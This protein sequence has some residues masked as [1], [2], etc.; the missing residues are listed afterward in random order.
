MTPVRLHH[1]YASTH[2]VMGVWVAEDQSL[3]QGSYSAAWG[4]AERYYSLD[5]LNNR[6]CFLIVLDVG[7]SRSGSQHS[8]V[9]AI[10]LACD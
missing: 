8:L 6:T 1:I 5:D 2:Q 9:G 7:N 4:S 3:R 10:S